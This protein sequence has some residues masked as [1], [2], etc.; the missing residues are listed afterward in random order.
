[1]PLRW[2]PLLV[3]ELARELNHRLAGARLR[4]LR[5][6][7]ATRDMVLLFRDVTLAWPLHPQRGAP[8]LLPPGEPGPEDLPLA[9]KVRCI[10]APAD[11]RILIMELLP[12][13]GRGARDLVVELLGNQW[14]AMVV[15][16]AEAR[17]RHVLVRREGPR[18]I[19]VGAVYTPPPPTKR[20]GVDGLLDEE[21]WTELLG[22]APPGDRP[23]AIVGS[24]AWTSP[25]NRHALVEGD[26]D[27]A[28]AL[29]QG[30]RSWR[31][32]VRATDTSPVLLET[33]RGLQPYPWP[34]PGVPSTSAAT[35]LDA[36]RAWKEEATPQDV[37]IEAALPGD[38]VGRLERATES[39]LRR[40][41]SLAAELAGVEDPAAL[42]AQGDLLLARFSEVPAGVSE[43]TL[44]GFQGESV[45]LEL[46][47]ARPAQENARA[48]YDRAAKAERARQRIPRLLEEA[49]GT[50]HTLQ[51]LMERVRSGQIA[52]QELRASLPPEGVERRASAAPGEGLPYRVYRS[53]GGLEIRVGRGSKHNDALTFHHSSPEDIWLHA[54][55]AAGAH[56]ILRWGRGE[57]PPARDLEEA[58]V[59]AA[60]HSRARTSGTVPVDW[61]QRKY[62]RKPRGAAPGS[63]SPQRTATLFVAPDPTLLE[64]LSEDGSAR[65]KD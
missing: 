44:E 37:G 34:I 33:S 47:P 43:V 26:P 40:R 50:F 21:R 1:M 60:L 23:R 58:A 15:E 22:P 41:T 39:A 49:S 53:S 52:A 25:L 24:L 8:V 14:N 30:Y 64:T 29:A 9:S 28:V 6:D 7:G 11:E 45:T 27:P 32:W 20:L 5:L 13:R 51:R 10:R 36:F 4:A 12:Q 56:V 42:R 35:L 17:I 63:V 38:L 55:Q 3:R 57:K 62:V 61:T 19:R 59:L 2:D 31:S 65:A 16:G 54:R 46:D 48:L 18:T